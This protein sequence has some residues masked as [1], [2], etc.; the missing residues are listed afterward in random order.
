MQHAGSVRSQGSRQQLWKRPLQWLQAY[1]EAEFGI[2][3]PQ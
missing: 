1:A 3:Y 2:F